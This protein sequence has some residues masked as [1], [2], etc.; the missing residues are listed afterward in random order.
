MK[1]DLYNVLWNK[2]NLPKL[3][4]SWV[5]MSEFRVRNLPSDAILIKQ[6]TETAMHRKNA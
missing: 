6:V 4:L 5:Y 3:T 2:K 1:S